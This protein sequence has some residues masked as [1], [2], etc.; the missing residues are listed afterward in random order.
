[1]YTTWCVAVT[2]RNK[3]PP[4]SSFQPEATA[5]EATV[6]S[7][8]PDQLQGERGVLDVAVGKQQQVPHAARRR[9]QAESPQGPPQ[10]CAAP[11][12]EKTLRGGRGAEFSQ[13]RV[14]YFIL[15]GQVKVRNI[16]FVSSIPALS[17]QLT[18]KKLVTNSHKNINLK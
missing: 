15:F 6:L 12:W 4:P 13:P 14:I 7:V 8:V 1:M 11:F 5:E 3:H 17:K 18:D 10:L 9:Q 16:L 2:D